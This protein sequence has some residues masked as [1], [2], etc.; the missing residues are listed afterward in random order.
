MEQIEAA[1]VRVGGALVTVAVVGLTI[2]T[3][4][5]FGAVVG[6][7]GVFLVS[8]TAVGRGLAVGSYRYMCL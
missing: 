8:D 7:A 4:G 5:L 1:F 3:G 2:A 6:I